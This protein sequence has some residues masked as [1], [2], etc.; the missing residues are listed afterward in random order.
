MSGE[1]ICSR[2]SKA[3]A[4]AFLDAEDLP[5]SDLTDAHMEHFFY[6][7]PAAAPTGLIG[8]EFCGSNALL[9]SLVVA[10]LHRS[11]GLGT[12]LVEHAEAHARSRGAHSIFL[13]TTT[14]EAFF[15]RHGYVATTRDRA[16]AE[17][18]ATREFAEICPTSS[19][20]LLKR[21]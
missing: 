20:L 18:R 7:G 5:S 2:P 12:A 1:P 6:C 11:V 17:I 9:R 10:P 8:L 4:V 14:A 13:L 19:A 15:K 3:A 16:P 21:L